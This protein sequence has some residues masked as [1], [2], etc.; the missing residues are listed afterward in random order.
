[1]TSTLDRQEGPESIGSILPRVLR[2]IGMP[3]DMI[4]EALD[5]NDVPTEAD[6]KDRGRRAA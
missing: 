3:D 5:P 2:A 6:R 4:R 1:M